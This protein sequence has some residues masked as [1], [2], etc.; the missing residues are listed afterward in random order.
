LRFLLINHEYTISG[1]SRL[2]FRLAIHLRDR[3]H[4]CDVMAILSHDGPLR[5]DYEIRGIRHRVTADFNS[6]DVV[7]CNTIFAAPIVSPAAKFTKTVWWIH[8]GGNGLNTLRERPSDWTVAFV[9]AT[10]IVFQTEYQR[11]GIYRQ[12]LAEREARTVFVIPIGVDVASAGP[13]IAKTRPFRILSIGTIDERKRHGDLIRAVDA[14]ER[15]DVE[16]V[17]IG[18]HYSIDE[19]ARR[20]VAGKPDRFRIFEAPNEDTLAWLRSADVF[21]LPS[22]AESQPLSIVEA[23]SLSKP[24]VLTDLPSYRGIWTNVR[25]CLTVP[26]GHVAGLTDALAALLA[27]RDLRERLGAAASETASR[28]SEAAFLA[29]FEA[30]LEAIV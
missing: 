1:A 5:R 8:E 15:D 6:Y 18:K 30:M 21:C 28:F 27:D 9:D 16:C 11:G 13:T 4:A 14:L 25:N 17:I 10:A 7:I 24:L 23:A 12:Y 3:G 29:R 20:I 26:V 22:G 19:T 2:M